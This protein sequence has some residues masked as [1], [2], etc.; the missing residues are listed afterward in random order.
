MRAPESLGFGSSDSFQAGNSGEFRETGR[1][2]FPGRLID[3]D[4]K[5]AEI[6]KIV[7]SRG[8]FATMVKDEESSGFTFKNQG[9]TKGRKG[10]GMDWFWLCDTSAFLNRSDCGTGWDPLLRQTYQLANFLIWFSCLVMAVGL[11]SLYRGKR[12]DLP[13]PG[14]L[15]LSGA[16]LLLGGLSH[17]GNVLGFYWAPYRLFTL[18]DLVTA[19][20]AVAVACQ[21]PSVVHGLVRL[22]P[23]EEVRTINKTLGDEL[24]QTARKNQE[25]L[26][27]NE[28]LKERVRALEHMLKTTAWIREKNAVMEELTKELSEQRRPSWK[29]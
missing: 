16:F 10:D 6:A 15:A 25:L 5:I 19:A 26:H 24:S 21:I 3:K 4:K 9:F 28:A 18:I 2:P 1:K 17:L 8:G 27:R 12:S 29:T 14:L 22:P 20:A 23:H 7:G 11:F 13:A